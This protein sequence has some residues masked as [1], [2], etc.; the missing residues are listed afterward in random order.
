MVWESLLR[1]SGA[2]AALA[3]ITRM[4]KR[5]TCSFAPRAGRTSREAQ[6]ARFVLSGTRRSGFR[7][8]ACARTQ[9]QARDHQVPVDL[10]DELVP[11]QTT[12]ASL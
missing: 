3:A 12:F 4:S 2:V 6:R 9:W 10:V 8:E 7:G 5:V 11:H 1:R